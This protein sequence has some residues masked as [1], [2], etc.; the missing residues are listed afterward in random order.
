MNQPTHPLKIVL[1]VHHFLPNFKAGAG[2]R[3]HRTATWLQR[4]G[5]VVMIVCI[6]SIR[7]TARSDLRCEYNNP[8]VE[9]RLPQYLAEEKPNIFYFIS[10][11]L[12][13]FKL[14]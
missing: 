12:A 7:D 2:W 3:A 10:E 1:V 9:T 13:W 5:Y 8:W 14:D 4:H 11:Y 6:E